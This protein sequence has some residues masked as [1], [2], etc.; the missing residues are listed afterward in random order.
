MNSPDAHSTTD[1]PWPAAP[2]PADESITM[3][4]TLAGV[5]DEAFDLYKRHFGLLAMIVAVGLIPTE[6]LRNTI[7]AIWLHPLDAHLSGPGASNPDSMVMLRIGQ[8]LFGEPRIGFPGLLAVIVLILLSA[9]VSVAV[10]DIYFGRSASVKDC[11]RRSRPYFMKMA[12]GYCL[13]ALVAIGVAFAS[14]IVLSIPAGLIAGLVTSVGA[15]EI[16]VVV[17]VVVVA[18][19]FLPYFIS[20]GIVARNFVFMTPLTVLEGLPAS[21]VAY[22][23]HQ[24]VGK[25]RFWRT[26]A[27][28]SALPILW[29]GF[30][31]IFDLSIDSAMQALHLPSIVDFT[32]AAA[33]G[34][35][36]HFFLAP[37]WTIFVTLLYYDYR[38]RR[39]GFDVRVLS[40][41]NPEPSS[42]EGAEK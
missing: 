15:P 38:V 7:I 22:R 20:C 18:F 16:A 39:E 29:I 2:E 1:S 19:M 17:V 21:F 10:S 41:S 4:Q 24:L 30:Q 36:T 14:L 31:S 40:L 12:G 25:K 35:A 11:Y 34:S 13:V 5:F 28:V 3:P 37:Y 8:F 23:N 32:A 26:W 33:L 9:P 42:S 27:A 6:I